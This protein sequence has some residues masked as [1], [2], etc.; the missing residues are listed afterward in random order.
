[1]VIPL[2]GMGPTQMEEEEVPDKIRDYHWIGWY[3]IFVLFMGVAIGC[4]VALKIFDALIALMIGI[5]AYWLTKD[6]CKNMSQQCCFSFGLMCCIQCVMEIII[7]A[8]SVGGRRTQ[9]QTQSGGSPHA[10]PSPFMGGGAHSTS[11]VTITTKTTPFFSEEMGWHYNLQSSMMI[12]NCVMFLFAA[13]MAK[14]SYG[15]YERSLFDGA[16]GESQPMGGSSGMGGG[17]RYGGGG[18]PPRATNAGRPAPHAN[19]MFGGSGQ[20]LG[21]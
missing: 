17:S 5:W 1:M 21:S 4:I 19:A 10:A 11:S 18:G 13:L 7:L 16:G 12:A 6:S 20:R 14:F 9:S 2:G 15:C 3:S 8:M